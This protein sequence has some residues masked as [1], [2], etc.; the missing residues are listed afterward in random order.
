MQQARGPS[1]VDCW[2][3]GSTLGIRGCCRC[4]GADVENEPALRLLA[5]RVLKLELLLD[6]LFY[7]L[8]DGLG[9]VA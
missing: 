7:A 8:L 9:H 2:A 4:C 1:A 3:F 6:G 5:P